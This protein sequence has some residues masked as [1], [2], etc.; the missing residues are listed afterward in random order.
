MEKKDRDVTDISYHLHKNEDLY[1]ETYEMFSNY[2]KAIQSG[3]N[4]RGMR[5]IV[6]MIDVMAR[7][8]SDSMTGAY[9]N[10]QATIEEN[11]ND[12]DAE[13]MRK[14]N[15]IMNSEEYKSKNK[16]IVLSTQED[17]IDS[18]RLLEE[19]LNKERENGNVDLS[20]FDKQSIN[21]FNKKEKKRN[22]NDDED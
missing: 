11:K 21:S 13:L 17:E 2:K 1:D 16:D 3:G 20:E 19:R 12:Q 5:D 10:R 9:R 6:G 18:K 8:R 14:V 7:I 22:K 4:F 15:A